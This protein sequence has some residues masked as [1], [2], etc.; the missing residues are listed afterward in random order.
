METILIKMRIGKNL[1]IKYKLLLPC[2]NGYLFIPEPDIDPSIGKWGSAA[3][4]IVNSQNQPIP[5]SNLGE[6]DIYLLKSKLLGFLK[7][8][9]ILLPNKVSV[10]LNLPNLFDGKPLEDDAPDNIKDLPY[11]AHYPMDESVKQADI[12]NY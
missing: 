11:L 9:L 1:P 6:I 2:F 10:Y 12:S 5:Y 3:K 7:A 8:C 4:A